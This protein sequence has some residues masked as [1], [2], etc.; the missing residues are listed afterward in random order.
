MTHL[1]ISN[2]ATLNCIC[3][4][5]WTSTGNDCFFM[6]LPSDGGTVAMNL[7]GSEAN[8]GLTGADLGAAGDGLFGK[9][10]SVGTVYFSVGYILV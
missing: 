1:M 2:T 6:K 9:T 7:L 5:R 4:I 3:S 10:G 8:T